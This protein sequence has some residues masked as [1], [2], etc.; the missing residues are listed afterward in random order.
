MVGIPACQ[1]ENWILFQCDHSGACIW[2]YKDK[3]MTKSFT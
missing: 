3:Q 2:V 1:G